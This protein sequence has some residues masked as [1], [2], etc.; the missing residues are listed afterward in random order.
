MERAFLFALGMLTIPMSCEGI[1][2]GTEDG[3]VVARFA[4]ETVPLLPV[5]FPVY[6]K[7]FAADALSVLIDETLSEVTYQNAVDDFAGDL[8][9]NI[10]GLTVCLDEFL[11]AAD[12][13]LIDN[14]INTQVPEIQSWV[15]DQLTG[16]L[17]FYNPGPL[18]VGV[19]EQI[20][21]TVGN[22]VSFDDIEVTMKVRNRT[23]DLWGVPIRFS[24]FMG[25]S[26][27]VMGKT[28][29]LRA[30]DADPSEPYTFVIQ[31]GEVQELVVSA[32]DLVDALNNF[33]TLSI[34]YDAVV[35]VADLQPDVFQSWLGRN[36]AD[37]DGN[38]V[39]DELATW[40]LIFEELS[41]SVS[42]Q[43]ELDVPVDFPSWMTDLIPEEVAL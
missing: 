19:G 2:I 36:R 27:G 11:G 26:S 40:G 14:T 34:D 12:Y 25:D 28:A 15:S 6:P 9:T 3:K 32:P 38:G 13:S 22:V 42:G 16:Q 39:A 7:A 24:L 41:I 29:L 10:L 30:P 31:P 5:G 20:G 4:S 33:R 35:E 1:D 17:R 8:C 18:G 23:D 21:R 43:G 37:S